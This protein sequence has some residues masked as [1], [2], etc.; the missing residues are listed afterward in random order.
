MKKMKSHNAEKKLK[1]GTLWDFSTSTLSENIKKLKDPS[2]KF[3]FEKSLRAE[4][5]LRE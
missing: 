1:R 2:V 5:T 3:F 4:N